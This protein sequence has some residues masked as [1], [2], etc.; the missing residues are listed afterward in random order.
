MAFCF[1]W[2]SSKDKDNVAPYNPEQLTIQQEAKL[3]LG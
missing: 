2:T 3:L 1:T